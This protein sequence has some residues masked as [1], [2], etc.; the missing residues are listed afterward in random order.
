MIDNTIIC[1]RLDNDENISQFNQFFIDDDL[2]SLK[3]YI[4]EKKYI[5][6]FPTFLI[7]AIITGIENNANKC[8]EYIAD[9]DNNLFVIQLI[10][11]AII[12]I[13]KMNSNEIRV[14]FDCNIFNKFNERK[15][16]SQFT[17][18]CLGHIIKTC[19]EMDVDN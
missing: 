17:K 15:N 8:I 18:S 5:G 14:R 3:K 12:K 4:G 1:V 11:N 10:E 19:N 6:V 13:S 2:S 7:D 9:Q 16:L